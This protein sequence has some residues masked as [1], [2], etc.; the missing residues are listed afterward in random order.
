MGNICNTYVE[1]PA[2]F[3]RVCFVNFFVS[4][5]LVILFCNLVCVYAYKNMMSGLAVVYCH[6]HS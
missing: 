3:A 4:V 6:F 1:L 5:M 2:S